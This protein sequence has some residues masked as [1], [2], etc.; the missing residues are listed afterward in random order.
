LIAG[1]GYDEILAAEGYPDGSETPVYVSGS[2]VTS[3]ANPW[4]DVDVY[5]LSDR[6]S[7]GTLAIPEG[8]NVVSQHFV[9][10]RRVDF[11]FWPPATVGE[12]AARLDRLDLAD[13]DNVPRSR[14]SYQEECFIHRLRVGKA[15]LNE[16][17]L[18][19]WRQRFDFAKLSAYQSQEA[20]R[21][22]D[23]VYEDVCGML[24]GGAF[25]VAML[26]ARQLIGFSVEA[27]VHRHGSTDPT[28]K[29]RPRQLE[30]VDDGSVFHR[31]VAGTYWSLEFPDGVGGDSSPEHCR[32][33]VERCLNF[34]RVLTSWVQS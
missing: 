18:A 3:Y 27:Y 5:V 30:A 1:L 22:S 2:I 24:D 4:S 10:D 8:P 20:I 17:E 11:E 26:S 19:A 7:I 21:A 23:G 13:A 16:P 34:S 14:F 6:G 12:L 15:L 9:G 29:W 31:E 25:D 28:V 33:Y 32:A